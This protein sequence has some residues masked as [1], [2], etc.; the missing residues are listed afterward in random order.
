MRRATERLDLYRF[1]ICVPC[2]SIL[3][4]RKCATSLTPF[5]T[6]DEPTT[7]PSTRPHAPSYGSD[8]ELRR[9]LKLSN[10]NEVRKG[11]MTSSQILAINSR[12]I[13]DR[14]SLLLCIS[15]CAHTHTHRYAPAYFLKDR[16]QKEKFLREFEFPY[17][18][19]KVS[20]RIQGPYYNKISMQ[21]YPNSISQIQ[22]LALSQNAGRS[23]A[24]NLLFYPAVQAKATHT[25]LNTVQTAVTDSSGKGVLVLVSSPS[26][27]TIL[28]LTVGGLSV[29]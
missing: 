6:W 7:V 12:T 10:R 24:N 2:G 8:P 23:V 4:L 18:K 26:V 14:N 3:L 20:G 27:L 19:R 15:I 11:L 13:Q 17:T 16:A 21:V 29:Q 28:L 25:V 1:A 22:M 5:P 9:K